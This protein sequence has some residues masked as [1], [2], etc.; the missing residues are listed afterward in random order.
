VHRRSLEV[1]LG[2]TSRPRRSPK[3]PVTSPARSWRAALAP[4]APIEPPTHFLG[5]PCG[6]EPQANVCQQTLTVANRLGHCQTT[7]TFANWDICQ[8]RLWY[9]PTVW[10]ICQRTGAIRSARSHRSPSQ[11]KRTRARTTSE[12]RMCARQ[13]RDV[14]RCHLLLPPYLTESNCRSC[15]LRLVGG[16]RL[17]LGG[18]LAL[19]RY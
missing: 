1:R 8:K 2:A 11:A 19:I 15:C 12:E 16:R 14:P 10:D 3:A 7:M 5:S 13:H 6:D 9:L 17:R 4:E 18:R